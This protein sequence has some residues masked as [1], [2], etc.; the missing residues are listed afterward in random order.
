MDDVA[1]EVLINVIGVPFNGS[2]HSVEN[3]KMTAIE[4]IYTRD[5]EI[6][7]KRKSLWINL[8]E[9]EYKGLNSIVKSY[10]WFQLGSEIET[11]LDSCAF[12]SIHLMM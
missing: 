10:I 3:L 4:K 8:F 1:F 5:E 11:Y 7:L 9:A 6:I 2:G 12:I